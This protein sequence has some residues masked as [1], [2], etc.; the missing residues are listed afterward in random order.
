MLLGEHGRN[1]LPGGPGDVRNTIN[2]LSM[3]TGRTLR[4]REPTGGTLFTSVLRYLDRR[5][6]S[7]SRKVSVMGTAKIIK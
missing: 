5:P 1:L 6:S 2:P 7:L 4:R 3:Y